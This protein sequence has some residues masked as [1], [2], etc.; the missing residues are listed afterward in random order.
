LPLSLPL[1]FSLS[2][3]LSHS[4]LL[5][6]LRSPSLTSSHS[7]SPSQWLERLNNVIRHC[8][9]CKK[10][11]YF[12]ILLCVLLIGGGRSIP[13]SNSRVTGA[14]GAGARD[15]LMRTENGFH[16]LRQSTGDERLR[17]Q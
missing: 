12:A 11:Y 5:S 2:L 7:R 9:K 15:V 8:I 14:F 6:H 10:Y 3:T 17:N 16:P 13:A 4:P 1:T